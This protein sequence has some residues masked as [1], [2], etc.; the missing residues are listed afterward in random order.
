MREFVP[1]PCPTWAKDIRWQKEKIYAHVREYQ[2][3]DYEIEHNVGHDLIEIL[4]EL[5]WTSDVFRVRYLIHKDDAEFVRF[6]L[7]QACERV[8]EMMTNHGYPPYTIRS[9]D[10]QEEIQ[11][12]TE[13]P[14]N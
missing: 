3:N 10:E 14:S 7:D 12:A 13:A 4:V 2:P 8:D 6:H 1:D 9:T 5:K 11:E